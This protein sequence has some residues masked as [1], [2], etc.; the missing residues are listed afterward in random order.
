VNGA[1]RPGRLADRI[2]LRDQR[3]GRREVATPRD[4]RAQRAQHDRHLVERAGVTGEPDLPDQHRAPGVVIPLDAG[5]RLSEPAPPA[6]LGRGD[7]SAGEGAHG[8]PQHPR[9]GGR[10]VGDHQREAVQDQIDRTRRVRQRGKGAGGAA[11]LRQRIG[12]LCQR[13]VRLLVPQR[14]GPVGH[15]AQQRMPEAHPR[16]ELRQARLGRRRS[17]LRRD[18]QPP[19]GPPHQRRITG[20]V[21]R[22]QP[23]QPHGLG[24]QGVQAA[25]RSSPRCGP[26][27][28]PHP[29]GRTR[30]PAARASARAAARAGPAGYPASRPRSDR[31]PGPREITPTGSWSPWRR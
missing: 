27:A 25:G 19:G 31:G 20:R 24:R 30:P 21:R 12:D 17:R 13:E 14:R 9:R 6:F 4:G 11:Y 15:R 10:P 23:Q 28:A 29:A 3:G 1:P 8:P 18:P 2:G 22:R 26:A 7:V 16:A 5:G